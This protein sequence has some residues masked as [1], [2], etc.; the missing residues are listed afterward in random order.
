MLLTTVS[1]G[2]ILCIKI[3][4]A[5]NQ[6]QE[7]LLKLCLEGNEADMMPNGRLEIEERRIKSVPLDPDP[8]QVR[9]EEAVQS[10]QKRP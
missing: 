4:K 3:D 2:G 9:L 5:C 10:A 8:N 7:C 1:P 6:K